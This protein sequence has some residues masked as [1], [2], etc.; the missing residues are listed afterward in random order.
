MFNNVKIIIY[1]KYLLVLVVVLL[2]ILI[3]YFFIIN[4][5]DNSAWEPA[6]GCKEILDNPVNFI[7]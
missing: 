3:P 7:K 1:F 6:N 5:A 2:I 4:N